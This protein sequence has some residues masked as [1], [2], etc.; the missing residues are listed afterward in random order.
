LL[1]NEFANTFPREPTRARKG[2]PFLGNGPVKHASLKLEAVFS[3]WPVPR[4]HKRT[5]K[6]RPSRV[7]EN[8]KFRDA[9]LPGIN[10]GAKELN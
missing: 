9:S 2:R 5:Q 4:G 3:V 10:L 7:V 1:G 8:S 6:K